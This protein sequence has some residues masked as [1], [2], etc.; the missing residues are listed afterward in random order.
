[1]KKNG[2]SGRWA[3]LS[4][5][6]VV[7]SK[8]IIM[9]KRVVPVVPASRWYI[10]NPWWK[11]STRGGAVAGSDFPRESFLA[12]APLVRTIDERLAI[13]IA[14]NDEYGPRGEGHQSAQRGEVA[15]KG[16]RSLNSASKSSVLRD[17]SYQIPTNWGNFLNE[18]FPDVACLSWTYFW[19]SDLRLPY[20]CGAHSLIVHLPIVP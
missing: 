15:R 6:L 7:T 20:D 11:N 17:N 3:A 13:A 1:M 16:K 19:S 2:H 10:H 12:V 5:K 8:Y 4:L 14:C 18:V 9:T